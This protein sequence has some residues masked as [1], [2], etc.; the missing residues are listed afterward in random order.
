LLLLLKEPHQEISEE[1]AETADLENIFKC[2]QCRNTFKSENGLKIHIGKSHKKVTQV[3]ATPDQLRQRPE[4]PMDT[5]IIPL[6][7]VSREEP[8][9]ALPV[10]CERRTCTCSNSNCCSC[11]HD[12]SC[13]CR[14]TNTITSFCDCEDVDPTHKD[15][16]KQPKIK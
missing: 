16:N 7:D 10:D 15:C 3:Q 14:Q 4:S 9:P 8:C 11:Y 2:D 13:E 6:L 5:S 1:E 12:D